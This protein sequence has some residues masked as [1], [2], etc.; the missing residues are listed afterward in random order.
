[1]NF[2]QSTNRIL[3]RHRSID[4]DGFV[5]RSKNQSIN[6]SIDAKCRSNGSIG[7]VSVSSSERRPNPVVR[8]GSG[9]ASGNSKCE[10]ANVRNSRWIGERL[11]Q[12]AE[13][14]TCDVVGEDDDDGES[15]VNRTRDARDDDAL[16]GGDRI[17]VVGVVESTGVGNEA[18]FFENNES[19]ITPR[20]GREGWKPS[21]GAGAKKTRG[22][23]GCGKRGTMCR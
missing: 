1:V 15:Y 7:T 19:T 5:D 16:I 6:Q 9:R 22:D 2:V 13:R 11:R 12:C 18:E 20:R 23:C 3:D 17:I 21:R 14:E 8:R 10:I 4:P